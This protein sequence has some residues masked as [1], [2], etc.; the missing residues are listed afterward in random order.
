MSQRP[1]VSLPGW[2]TPAD[3]F[4]ATWLFCFSRLLPNMAEGSTTTTKCFTFMEAANKGLN[5]VVFWRFNE[6]GK[7]FFFPSVESDYINSAVFND[8]NWTLIMWKGADTDT[9]GECLE[10][11]CGLPTMPGSWV[12]M[13]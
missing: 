7:V 11:C 5:K 10:T 3:F 1:Q 12:R 13:D 4:N 8:T 6:T 9:E 2:Q